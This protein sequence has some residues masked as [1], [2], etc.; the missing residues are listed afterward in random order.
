[1]SAAG[2]L[3]APMRYDTVRS[4]PG[5]LEALDWAAARAALA[6]MEAEA[7]TV[8]GRVVPEDAIRLTRIADMRYRKQGYE[9]RTPVPEGTPGPELAGPLRAAFEETYRGLYGHTVPQAAVDVVSWRIVAEGPRPE[10]AIGA[11]RG[12]VGGAT[13][14]G[15]RRIWLPEADGFAPVPVHDRYA[16]AP[17]AELEGP[18][19]VEERES[20][21]V[22]NG[23]ALLRVDDA[24]NLIAE[25]R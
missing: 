23:P 12:A 16:L 5:P 8:L 15:E 4:V 19:I 13:L 25:P 22:V 2:F 24:A 10:L 3:V 6:E 18:C 14:K 20:T 1:M 17:G 7:R 21:V 9:L 11:T